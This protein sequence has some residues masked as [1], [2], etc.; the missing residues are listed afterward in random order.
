MGKRRKA[1][2]VAL[3]FLYQLDQTGAD[4]PTPFEDVFWGRHPVDEVARAFAS[5]L[6]RGTKAKHP[7]IDAIIAET[8][9]HGDLESMAV[10]DPDI[11]R[12]G[13]HELLSEPTVPG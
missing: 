10:V 2:E 5:S 12:M 3:Q 8:A 9:E 11:F 4:D 13:V 6:V 7:K 1:R